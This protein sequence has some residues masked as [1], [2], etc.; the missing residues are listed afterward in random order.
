MFKE[1]KEYTKTIYHHIEDINKVIL[2]FKKKEAHENTEVEMY[3]MWNENS[4][5]ELKSRFEVEEEKKSANSKID[6]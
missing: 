3:N 5:E 2:F 1:L 6:Q 4:I